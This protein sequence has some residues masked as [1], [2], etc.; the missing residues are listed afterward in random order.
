[1]NTKLQAELEKLQPKIKEWM[2]Y[3]H[4]NPELNMDTP[5]TAA[6]IA[7]HLKEWGYEVAEGVGGTGIVA[8]MTVG[9]GERKIGLRADFD[10]LPILED[11]ELPY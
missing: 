10:A 4:A 11:N 6:F 9:A 8:S 1:M 2:D 3:M 7:K 5:K